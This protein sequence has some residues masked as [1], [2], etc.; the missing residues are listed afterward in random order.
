LLPLRIFLSWRT[1]AYRVDA[2]GAVHANIPGFVDVGVQA[3]AIWQLLFDVVNNQPSAASVQTALDYG[4]QRKN[5][6][7]SFNS[8]SGQGALH[9]IG[10]SFAFVAFVARASLLG[11]ASGGKWALHVDPVALSSALRW[12]SSPNQIATLNQASQHNASGL[13]AAASG[14]LLGSLVLNDP[15]LQAA[16]AALMTQALALQ[17]QAGWFN[18]RG[19]YGDG[20]DA[21]YQGISIH[22]LAVVCSYFPKQVGWTTALQSA[23]NWMKTKIYSGVPSS[24]WLNMNG[25][26]RSNGQETP[27]VNGA[28]EVLDLAD[29]GFGMLLAGELLADTSAVSIGS[30]VLALYDATQSARDVIVR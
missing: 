6:D 20:F 23:V 22:H 16:G 18:E 14:L 25:S 24:G 12:L 19:P 5:Q 2:T 15:S 30:S 9:D 1:L 8:N 7:G 29:V 28:P 4:F 3:E 21:V 27:I 26:T 17:N 13:L 11:Q 10:A